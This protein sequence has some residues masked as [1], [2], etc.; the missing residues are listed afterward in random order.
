MRSRQRK[1]SIVVIKGGGD[2]GRCRMACL[3]LRGNARLHVIRTRRSVEIRGVAAEAIRRCSCES[4]IDVAGCA[5]KRCVRASKRKPGN[6]QMIEFRAKPRIGRVAGLAFGPK[7]GMVRHRLLQIRH[8]T[9]NA[10]GREPGELALG[11]ALVAIDALKRRVRAKQRKPVHV[12]LNLLRVKIPALNGVAL[13]AIRSKLPA[14]NIRV[15][16]RTMRAGV[17]K[18]ETRMAFRAV[19]ILVHAEQWKLCAV[20]IKFR[21]AADRCPSA[22]CVAIF[23]RHVDR[24]VRIVRSGCLS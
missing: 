15:A 11:P 19:H 23:A 7:R 17:R 3:A 21:L 1:R 18:N 12:L 8:M 10:F 14:M 4:P 9:R 13:F 2:P 5:I 16:I 22:I 6:L 24:A 20:V